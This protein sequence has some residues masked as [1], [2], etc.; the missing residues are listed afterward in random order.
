MDI[1]M[2]VER[3][4]SELGESNA[5]NVRTKGIPVGISNRHVHLSRD[6]ANQLFGEEYPFVMLKA[7]R[8]TGQYACSETVTLVGPGGV[9][10]KVRVLGPFRSETQVEL[11]ASDCRELGIPSVVRDSGKTNHT[12]GLTLCGPCGCMAIEEGVI[13]AKRHIHMSPEDSKALGCAD[14]E[15]VTIAVD[16]E[17][18]GL[19]D[20]VTVRVSDA[21]VL[22]CHIDTEEANGMG[23]VTKDT[24][25][26]HRR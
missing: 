4:L 5:A 22:E 18:G 12:P 3:V 7:L 9:I 2:I 25:A 19:L 10:E 13:V 20:N 17:R 24:V 16:G 6:V 8:Q 11:L 14:G 26:I 1:D 21:S 15:S 23:I